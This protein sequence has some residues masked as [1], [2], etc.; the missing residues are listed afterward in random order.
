MNRVDN[1]GVTVSDVRV[2]KTH[3]DRKIDIRGIENHEITAIPLVTSG[4]VTSNITG[5]FVVIL[6]QNAHHGK[7]KTIH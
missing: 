7:N 4:G 3:P 5:E 6:H 2:I 1:S